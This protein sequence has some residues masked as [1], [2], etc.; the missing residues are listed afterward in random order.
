MSN[1][2]I[3]PGFIQH[4]CD[5]AKRDEDN[6]AW[7]GRQ[8]DGG[9]NHLRELICAYVSGR[10]GN[11]PAF[12]IAE[13]KTFTERHCREGDP[14]YVEYQRLKKNMEISNE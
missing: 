5:K 7:G 1:I 8:D 6:A 2:K 12:W 10:D 13:L 4:L 9:A 11:V 14:D 3:T